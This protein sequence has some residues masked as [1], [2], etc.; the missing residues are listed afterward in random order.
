MSGANSAHLSMELYRTS[1]KI[2][3]GKFVCSFSGLHDNASAY[4]AKLAQDV[5]WQCVLKELL[6]P[7]CYLT[8]TTTQCY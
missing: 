1:T 4:I 3:L 7:A 6:H 5:M 8:Q 2:C